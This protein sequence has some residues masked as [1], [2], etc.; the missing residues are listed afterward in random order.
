MCYNIPMPFTAARQ[1]AGYIFMRRRTGQQGFTLFEVI[2][3]LALMGIMASVALPNSQAIHQRTL[4]Q[5]TAREVESALIMARQLSMDESRQ[6]EVLLSSNRF[7]IRESLAFSGRVRSWDY[8]AGIEKAR[9][10]DDRISFNRKGVTGYGQF[11]LK[12]RLDQKVDITIQIGT[13]RVVVSEL[14]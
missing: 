1:K 5:N 14:Y 3:V 10:S 6:Y 12:N 13:G 8:P 11:T 9:T 2:I 4:L 7:S